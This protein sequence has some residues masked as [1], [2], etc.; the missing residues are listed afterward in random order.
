[1][2]KFS[3]GR[4]SAIG[5]L[6]L[7]RGRG[8][9]V[10]VIDMPVQ[11]SFKRRAL[12]TFWVVGLVVG[13]LAATVA[14]HYLHP[15][16]GALFGIVIGTITGALVGA[17]VLAWPVL[18]VI[19][20]WLPEILL[21][22]GLVYG[23][24][25][26]METAN[27]AV[28]LLVVVLV[29]GVPAAIGPIRRSLIA[30]AWCFIV[31]HRLRKCFASFIASNWDG[32]MPLILT[33]R[34]TPAGERVWVWL[35][36]GL[37]VADLEADGQLKRLAVACWANEVR[38]VRCSRRNA[39]LV[40]VDVARRDPLTGRVVSPIPDYVP[41]DFTGNAPTSPAAPPT[42]LDLPD[43]PEEADEQDKP[44]PRSN[45]RKPRNQATTPASTYAS[46]NADY[47]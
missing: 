8:G 24:T 47:A 15:I 13:L 2:S 33:A 29:V 30:L 31:R 4:G 1:V 10:T 3:K 43:V 23:W 16:V 46:D 32:S 18:R 14:S 28:S 22:L 42:A 17:V 45:G 19:W 44:E 11:R 41:E 36:P 27:L 39:A 9:N 20:Y 6:G 38:V 34:P 37:S 26:L 21:S 5:G 7:G 25:A 40:R 12:I 35:R